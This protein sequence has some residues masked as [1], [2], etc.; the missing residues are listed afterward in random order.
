MNSGKVPRP[1]QLRN[2]STV[3]IS[4]GPENHSSEA[5]ASAIIKVHTTS[6]GL[7]PI[8]SDHSAIAIAPTA[9]QKPTIV[10][11]LLHTRSS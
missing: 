5:G 7:R 6:G 1:I 11:T 8:R 10:I 9:G 3:R 2:I 4:T